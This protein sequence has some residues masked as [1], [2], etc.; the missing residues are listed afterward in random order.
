MIGFIPVLSQGQAYIVSKWLFSV[1]I[2]YVAEGSSYFPAPGDIA[3]GMSGGRMVPNSPL[4]V[5]ERLCT[6][7]QTQYVFTHGGLTTTL[8]VMRNSRVLQLLKLHVQS[9]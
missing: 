6:S 5:G 1:A 7:Q 4:P 2:F 8:E 9:V 3:G